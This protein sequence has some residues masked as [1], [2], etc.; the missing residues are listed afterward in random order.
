MLQ[1]ILEAG[2]EARKQVPERI[3]NLIHQYKAESAS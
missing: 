1:A 3:E 2:Q